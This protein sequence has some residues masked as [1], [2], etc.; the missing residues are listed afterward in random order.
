YPQYLLKW[1]SAYVPSTVLLTRH[2]KPYCI[3]DVCIFRLMR[4]ESKAFSA[5]VD[6]PCRVFCGPDSMVELSAMAVNIDTDSL[7]LTVR[8]GESKA[9]PELG[10]RVS[11]EMLL[12]GN[13]SQAKAKCLT[14]RA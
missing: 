8:R 11:L 12:P 2:K 14:V 9:F 5:K 4:T 6:L 7:V 13:A 1:V 3:E 10:E